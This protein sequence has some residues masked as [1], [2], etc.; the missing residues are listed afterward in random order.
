ME[1]NLLIVAAGFIAIPLWVC[2][3]NAKNRKKTG[4]S[5]LLI[6]TARNFAPFQD[7]V[8][9]N[10][11]HVKLI[12]QLIDES[13]FFLTTNKKE[14]LRELTESSS[15]EVNYNSEDNLLI[16]MIIP[17]NNNIHQK[18]KIQLKESIISDFNSIIFAKK[19]TSINVVEK[20]N[21]IRT[22]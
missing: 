1:A 16:H 4:T 12:K 6:I 17:K 22:L 20:Y 9:S 11:L 2:M 19:L 10:K 8:S 3:M 13:R 7:H 14:T 15:D 21:F 18:N 5:I